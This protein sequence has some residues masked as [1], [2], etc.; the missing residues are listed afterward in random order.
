VPLLRAEDAISG[1]CSGPREYSDQ[2]SEEKQENMWSIVKYLSFTPNV[3]YL[4]HLAKNIN[5]RM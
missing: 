1:P 5:V 2:I 4:L 3:G